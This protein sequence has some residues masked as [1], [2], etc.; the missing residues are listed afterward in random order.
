MIQ[1]V[2]EQIVQQKFYF[3]DAMICY[4]LKSW[5]FFSSKISFC[6]NVNGSL[7]LDWRLVTMQ[8]WA[9]WSLGN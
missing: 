7:I 1:R 9:A 6:E 2:I 4:R 8:M 3:K 5:R